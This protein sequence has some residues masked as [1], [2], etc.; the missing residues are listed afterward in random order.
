[1]LYFY[2]APVV[3]MVMKHV[4]PLALLLAAACGGGG[5]SSTPVI[6]PD[7][8]LVDV[9]PNSPTTGQNLSPRGYIGNASGYYFGAAT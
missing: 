8:L 5:G 1:G 7:F 9:N 4:L 6:A 3:E 2:G